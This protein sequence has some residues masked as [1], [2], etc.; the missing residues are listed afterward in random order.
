MSNGKSIS[1]KMRA[2]YNSVMERRNIGDNGCNSIMS[3]V[4]V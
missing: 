2:R 3:E 4:K 1:K